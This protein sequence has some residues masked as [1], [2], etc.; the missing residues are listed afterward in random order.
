MKDGGSLY[1][2]DINVGD[3][4]K[5]GPYAVT[6]SELLEFNRKWD[7]LPI[8]LSQEKAIEKGYKDITA[9]GQYTLCIKQWML[10]QANWTNAVIGALGFDEMRFPLP[11]YPGDDI[12]L[13]IECLATRPSKSKSDRGILTFFFQLIN[14]NDKVVL[15]YKDTVMFS[16]KNSL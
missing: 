1:F 13:E 16:R 3:Q 2:E 12:S 7:P 11:V 15:H 8:H 14:Q 9:S 6:R 4:L 5:L 10:N